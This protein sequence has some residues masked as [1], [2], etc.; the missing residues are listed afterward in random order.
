[1]ANTNGRTLQVLLGLLILLVGI[2]SGVF[3]DRLGV[4]K[5]ETRLEEKVYQIEQSYARKDVVETRLA[6]IEKQL[7]DVQVKLDQLLERRR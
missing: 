5:T 6:A 2:V 1:M 7:N 4:A 3:A